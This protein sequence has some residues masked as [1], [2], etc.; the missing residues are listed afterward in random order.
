MWP[1]DEF[2]RWSL[3]GLE[4]GMAAQRQGE[5]V[6]LRFHRGLFRA[7]FIE[8]K[9][10]IE[11][12]TFVGIARNVGLDMN[13]FLNDIEDKTFQDL[14]RRQCQEAVDK[15]FVSAVPTVLIGGKRRQIGMVDAEAYLQDL[16]IL[17]VS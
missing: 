13:A 10:L 4:A 5:E 9:S 14:V 2:P 15:Y 11:K 12:D 1:H 6:F 16:A 8:S 7:F 3:P 17:G